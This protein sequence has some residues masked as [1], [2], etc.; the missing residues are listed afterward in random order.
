MG[1]GLGDNIRCPLL[2]R[3]SVLKAEILFPG[4]HAS[5]LVERFPSRS[6]GWDWL[7]FVG[8]GRLNFLSMYA[9]KFSLTL[10]SGEARPP[11]SERAR[12]GAARGEGGSLT[13]FHKAFTPS[14]VDRA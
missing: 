2:I 1:Q 6:P 11:A 3:L 10:M 12:R 7:T 14:F 5:M 9:H 13:S 8:N 4:N